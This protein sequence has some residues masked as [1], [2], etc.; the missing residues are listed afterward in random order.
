MPTTHITDGGGHPAPAPGRSLCGILP[1]YILE[2]L[3]EADDPQVRQAAERTLEVDAAFRERR[4]EVPSLAPPV[5]AVEF[6]L[7]RTICD[8][9]HSLAL[10][11]GVVR[12]EGAD[13]LA[14]GTVNRAYDSLGLTFDFFKEAYGRHSIDDAN[15]PLDAT[16]HYRRNYNNAFWDGERMVFGDGDGRVFNDFT[17]SH[18][19]IG[20]ELTHGVTEYTAG[21]VYQDQSGA[22]NESVSDVFGSLVKQYS[23]RQTAEEADWLIGA[24]IFTPA[25]HGQA[26]RSMK[27]PG[28]A[29]N[30][31][32][33][34]GQDP[35]PDN[36]AGY[37]DDPGDHGGVHTNSGIPNHAFY[38]IASAIGG[39]AWERA[40]Q[41]WYDTLTSG[42]LSPNATFNEFARATVAATASRYGRGTEHEAVLKAWAHV[43]VSANG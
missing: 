32:L 39:F 41:I 29:F 17:V 7:D 43:G 1:P 27:A 12:R 8:T 14:D 25:I 35:Q 34:G 26:L 5:P 37:V 23:R 30:D 40:G 36:M 24:G 13:P 33:L 28:T 4:T 42:E 31:P 10:P 18:D 3:A 19:I 22:L 21:L 11:G 2:K 20:H 9:R 38:L 16:V 6:I 15:L